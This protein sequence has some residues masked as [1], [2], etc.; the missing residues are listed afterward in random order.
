MVKYSEV[1]KGPVFTEKAFRLARE[2]NTYTFKVGKKYN[3]HQIKE[4]VEQA[5][6]VKVIKVRTANVK[7]KMKRFGWRYTGYT[8]SWKKA[9]VTIEEGKTLDIYGEI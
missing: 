3:K 2:N 8:S 6:G 1:I 4:A 7:P 9:Y 5:F